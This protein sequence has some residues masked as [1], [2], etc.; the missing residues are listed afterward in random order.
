MREAEEVENRVDDAVEDVRRRNDQTKKYNAKL[1]K[2][3]ENILKMDK[4]NLKV[5]NLS[6]SWSFFAAK[7]DRL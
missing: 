1:Q 4:S 2:H 6:F 5:L 7:F 3:A